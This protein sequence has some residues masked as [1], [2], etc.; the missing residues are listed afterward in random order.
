MKLI[1]V[2][3]ACMLP[4]FGATAVQQAQ[5]SATP[6]TQTATEAK[7][8]APA[9]APA[10]AGANLVNPVKPTK[11]LLDEAKQHYGWD[12]AMCHGDSGKGNGS[13]ATS[14]KLTMPDFTNPATLKG[15]TDGQLFTLIR[16]GEGKMP[17]ED[18]ARA[19]D[20]M[21]WNLVNYLRTMSQAPAT[22][23]S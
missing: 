12:C 21:V 19:N 23:A 14:E 15:L 11:A 7:A 2:A 5:S 17:S 18:K 10:V 22:P 8:A 6:Q 3:F 20:A 13:L 9:A 4:L 16:K 1:L